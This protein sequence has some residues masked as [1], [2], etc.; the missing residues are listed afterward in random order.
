[1]N[2][3]WFYERA[4]T[5]MLRKKMVKSLPALKKKKL[6]KR[7]PLFWFFFVFTGTLVDAVTSKKNM[8][9]DFL[10]R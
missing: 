9:C 10:K 7:G 1:M 8:E 5:C 6:Q 2:K 4:I 3:K